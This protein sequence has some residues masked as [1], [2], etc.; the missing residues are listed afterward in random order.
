MVYVAYICLGILILNCFTNILY[1]W[2][3]NGI[4]YPILIIIV[5]TNLYI[6]SKNYLDIISN[7]LSQ[8]KGTI[9]QKI[10]NAINLFIR[11]IRGLPGIIPSVPNLPMP[12]END[13]PFKG[14]RKGIQYLIINVDI[15]VN[16]YKSL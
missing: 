16:K 5:V 15:D 11:A 8:K 9:I 1:I 10:H 6:I 2:K 3:L 13:Q 12:S 14:I 4:I 7:R